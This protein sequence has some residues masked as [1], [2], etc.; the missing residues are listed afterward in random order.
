MKENEDNSLEQYSLLEFKLKR[1]EEE[2][3]NLENQI[4]SLINQLDSK[5]SD[6]ITMEV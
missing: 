1:K 3:N 4:Q 6:L 2:N 5:R